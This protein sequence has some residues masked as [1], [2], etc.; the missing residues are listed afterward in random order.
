MSGR[1][2][3][4]PQGLECG[5]VDGAAVGGR[6]QVGRDRMGL[7]ASRSSICET[8]RLGLLRCFVDVDSEQEFCARIPVRGQ[9][10]EVRKMQEQ[11][12]ICLL[13]LA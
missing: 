9:G 8:M 2:R 13:V 6:A 1:P 4:R 10:F 3:Y 12:C 7:D 11:K 5:K